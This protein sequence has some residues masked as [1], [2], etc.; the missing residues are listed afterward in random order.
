MLLYIGMLGTCVGSFLNVVIYRLPRGLS[1]VQPRSQ[2]PA[3]NVPLP[4]YQMVPLLSYCV[5]RGR[6]GSCRTP[7]ARTYFV[8]E[9]GTGL[10]FATLFY[11]FGDMPMIFGRYA[12]L[13]ALLITM[14]EIDRRHGIIPNQLIGVGLLL[15]IVGMLLNNPVQIGAHLLA[16][17]MAL[18]LL[19]CIR[20]ISQRIWGQPGMGMG[21]V[22]LA[23][24]LG[25][26]LGW[27]VLWVLYLAVVLGGVFGLVGLLTRQL[28]RR[29]RLP[30]APFVGL[31]TGLY[32]ALPPNLF[33][34]W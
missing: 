22:K 16:G 18:L 21:D 27:S 9:V 10:L 15:G 19:L 2:C 7:I 20:I 1:T 3:C 11:G 8:V 31:A 13:G 32:L 30:F 4:W 5:L 25:V 26:F 34:L 17:L 29:A 33:L 23:V 12:V 24:M 14:A 28:G 6:C